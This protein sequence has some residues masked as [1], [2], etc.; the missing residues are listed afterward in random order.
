[1]EWVCARHRTGIKADVGGLAATLDVDP[2]TAARLASRLAKAG[3]LLHF[4]DEG[5][6][7]PARPPEMMRVADA[8]AVGIDMASQGRS[9]TVGGIVERLRAAQMQ[10]VE[11][12]TFA[13]R[14]P[15]PDP[16]RSTVGSMTS[17]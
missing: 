13:D 16:P 17:L 5:V 10:S 14:D 3:L 11:K 7:V 12:L 2:A 8:L 6:I 15:A 1:M 4:P 9:G